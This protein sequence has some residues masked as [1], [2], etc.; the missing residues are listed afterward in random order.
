MIKERKKRTIGFDA[1]SASE[2]AQMLDRFYDEHH[3][4]KVEVVYCGKYGL[5]A[6]LTWEEMT[7]IPETLREEYELRGEAY[8]CEDCRHR[9]PCTDGRKRCQWYCTRRPRGTTLDSPACNNFY[10]ELEGEHGEG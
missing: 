10:L 1:D 9:Q 7:H 8:T 6:L 4:D 3:G 2:L 5:S